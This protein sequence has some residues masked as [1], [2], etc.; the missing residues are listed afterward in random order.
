[1]A[2]LFQ[3]HVCIF[4]D[5]LH[6]CALNSSWGVGGGGEGE[7]DGEGDSENASLMTAVTPWKESL[8]IRR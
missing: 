8:N 5:S 1:M 4:K 2:F 3:G 6:K 7:R